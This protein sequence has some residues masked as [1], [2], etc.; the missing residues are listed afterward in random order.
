MASV[1]LSLT[2]AEKLFRQCLLE[3]RNE[4]QDIP[5]MKNLVLRFTGGWVRDK[6]LGVQSHD[7]DVAL[8][9][10]TGWQFGQAMQVFMEKHG[11][12]YEDE[13][14]Q[15]GFAAALK[16]LHKIAAN[17]EKSKH[18]ETIT[19][20][21]FGIDV[22][23]VN[24]RKEVYNEDSRNP[25]MEFGTAEEDA[26]RRDA[27]VNALFYNLDTQAVEDFTKR[28]FEDMDKK[29]IR[30][31]LEPYQTFKDDP[32]RV[33]RLIRFACRLGYEI[34]PAS[35]ESMKD[36]TIHEALRLKISRERVGVEIDKIVRGPDPYTGL[37]YIIDF[38]LFTTVFADPTS[39]DNLDASVA[40]AAYDGLK[41]IL[42]ERSSI[43]LALKPK[44]NAKL[45]WF[46][47]TYTPWVD[48]A[49][50]A[51][52]ASR[53]GIKATNAE[54]KILKD[55]IDLRS[56]IKEVVDLAN[57]G[58]AKRSD[59]G[60]LIRK[61]KE[62]WRAHILYSL[63]CDLAC[64]IKNFTSIADRYQRLLI[65]IEEKSL[66]DAHKILPILKGNEIHAVMGGPKNRQWM[67]RAVDMLAEWQFDA[68]EPTTDQA[69]EMISSKKSELGLT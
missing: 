67:G 49:Q 54:S 52:D 28:G 21:M 66:E 55:A 39:T 17:P 14:S 19:T 32:L 38:D 22:D 51:Y 48:S 11:Q 46:L 63:L 50:K 69:I 42:D 25:Q 68:V 7:I 2:P 60:M 35:R 41:K 9:S 57:E 31:P 3:C 8:S 45:S 56:A 13:A 47:A 33:L 44:D 29:I 27:T 20:K 53:T 65:F 64:D 59:V 6:L 1:S 36:K 40:L 12:K 61:C 34:D 15:Q 37:K 18:L 16:N 30:T 26:V 23:F 62:A 4:M 43:C 58:T 10:M 5:G 24:L